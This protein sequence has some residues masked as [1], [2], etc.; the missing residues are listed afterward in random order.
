MSAIDYLR[1][2]K[3]SLV[4][5]GY[6]LSRIRSFERRSDKARP[7]SRFET[8]ALK[9][10]RVNNVAQVPASVINPVKKYA[11]NM[12]AVVKEIARVLTPGGKAVFVVGN[13]T[14]KGLTVDTSLIF[15]ELASLNK[16]AFTGES[17][18]ALPENRRYLPPPSYVPKDSSLS[19]RLS[20]ETILTFVKP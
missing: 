13:P 6:S 9:A 5:M 2:H 12:A 14:M 4:W 8:I 20:E 16:L 1:G 19:K 17:T 15:K 10:M 11:L 3:L 7:T 18:R